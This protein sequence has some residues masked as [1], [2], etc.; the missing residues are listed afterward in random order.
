[1]VNC[2]FAAMPSRSRKSLIPEAGSAFHAGER[3]VTALVSYVRVGGVIVVRAED[4]SRRNY[5]QK[6]R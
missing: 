6:R 2:A 4:A 3:V 1:M 5:P